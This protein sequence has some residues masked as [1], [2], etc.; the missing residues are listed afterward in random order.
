MT[1]L[2]VSEKSHHPIFVYKKISFSQRYDVHEIK[3]KHSIDLICSLK[4]WIQISIW[5]SNG[6]TLLHPG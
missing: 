5:Q 6:W 2:V 3:I 1:S 4:F